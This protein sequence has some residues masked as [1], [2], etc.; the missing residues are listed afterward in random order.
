MGI[1]E[2]AGILL[3]LGVIAWIL[4]LYMLIARQ[5]QAKKSG[6]TLQKQME[7]FHRDYQKEKP[8]FRRNDDSTDSLTF[9]RE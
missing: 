1:I 3:V 2:I 4:I 9:V 8:V 7:S 6:D 5:D